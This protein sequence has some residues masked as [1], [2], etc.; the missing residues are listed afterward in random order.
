MTKHKYVGLDVHQATT[1]G[2]LNV[3]GRDM[4]SAWT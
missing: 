1:G 3:C 4:T 2:V